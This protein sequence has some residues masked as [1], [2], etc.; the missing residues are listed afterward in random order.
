[1]NN[2]FKKGE[3]YP[4]KFAIKLRILVND[5]P[6]LLDHELDCSREELPEELYKWCKDYETNVALCEIVIESLLVDGEEDIKD[7]VLRLEVKQFFNLD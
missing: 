3:V 1:M 5:E 4:M 6:H 7:E 2:T